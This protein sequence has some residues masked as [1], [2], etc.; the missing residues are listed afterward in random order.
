M[1]KKEKNYLSCDCKYRRHTLFV[2]MGW[3]YILHKFQT[4]EKNIF[5]SLFVVFA[6]FAFFFYLHW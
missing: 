3:G 6:H 5:P 4:T 1:I 2:G